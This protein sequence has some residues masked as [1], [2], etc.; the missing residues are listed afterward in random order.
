MPV[1]GW[2]ARVIPCCVLVFSLV[3][4]SHGKTLSG[5]VPVNDAV[6][7]TRL[8]GE[9]GL[10]MIDPGAPLFTEEYKRTTLKKILL[11]VSDPKKHAALRAPCVRLLRH[12]ILFSD[13][14]VKD[15]KDLILP[16]VENVAAISGEGTKKDYWTEALPELSMQC[17]WNAKYAIA[18]DKGDKKD[19]GGKK[20]VAR[21][22]KEALTRLKNNKTDYAGDLMAWYLKGSPEEAIVKLTALKK[23]YGRGQRLDWSLEKAKTLVELNKLKTKAEK[24]STLITIARDKARSMALRGWAVRKLTDFPGKETTEFL[25]RVFKSSHDAKQFYLGFEAQE[26]LKKLKLIHANENRYTPV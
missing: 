10:V 20:E 23:A 25:H 17:S 4:D 12:Y 8:V 24:M 6:A 26:A 2:L 16:V 21:L 14:P 18:R 9:A 7:Y 3:G 11:M 1:N 13:I 15:I 5:S 22:E 19:K